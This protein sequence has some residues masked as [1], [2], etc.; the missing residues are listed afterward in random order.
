MT[1]Q[2]INSLIRSIGAKITNLKWEEQFIECIETQKNGSE[3]AEKAIENM[4]IPLEIASQGRQKGLLR[5]NVVYDSHITE[6]IKDLSITCIIT[7]YNEKGN[8]L[9]SL[10]FIENMDMK[11]D[12][13][14][15]QDQ[16][17]D[18][19]P[20]YIYDDEG[21]EIYCYCE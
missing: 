18:I 4:T 17:Y 11:N 14:N 9:R 3:T 6:S 10:I 20:M 2:E 12:I 21:N 16:I 15:I 1:K 5:L 13:T 19:N 8:E 7:S